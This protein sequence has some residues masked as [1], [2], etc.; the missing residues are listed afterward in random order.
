MYGRQFLAGHVKVNQSSFI[1]GPMEAGS[2]CIDLVAD[3]LSFEQ[4]SA[5]S[6]FYVHQLPSDLSLHNF[7]MLRFESLCPEGFSIGKPVPINPY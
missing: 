1:R 2:Q 4:V 7:S 5:V 3:T 6:N